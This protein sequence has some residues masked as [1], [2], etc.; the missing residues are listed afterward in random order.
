MSNESSA[1]N[2]PVFTKEPGMNSDVCPLCGI[3]RENAGF[4]R[5]TCGDGFLKPGCFIKEAESRV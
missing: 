5:E 4:L 3:H 2:E 1:A